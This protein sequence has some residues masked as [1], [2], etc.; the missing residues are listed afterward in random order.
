MSMPMPFPPN[1]PFGPPPPP[2]EPSY[3]RCAHVVHAVMSFFTFGFWL[4]IWALAAAQ[5][6][7]YNRQRRANYERAYREWQDEYRRWQYGNA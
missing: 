2:L 3:Y 5:T 6:E 7:S 1:R 4:I